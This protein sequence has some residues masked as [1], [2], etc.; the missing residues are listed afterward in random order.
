MANFIMLVGLPCSGKSAYAEKLKKETDG[1]IYRPED[2]IRKTGAKGNAVVI[3][4]INTGIRKNLQAGKTVILD[5]TNT[6]K[7][8]RRK[9]MNNLQE[10]DCEKHCVL[11]AA[12][13]EECLKTNALKKQPLPVAFLRKSYLQF[14]TPFYNEGFD[15]IWLYYPNPRHKGAYGSYKDVYKRNPVPNTRE[16]IGNTNRILRRVAQMDPEEHEYII[17]AYLHEYGKLYHSLNDSLDEHYLNISAYDSLFFETQYNSLL[18]SFLI[19][20][21]LQNPCR[22]LS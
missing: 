13:F 22:E 19:G 7:A 5:Y 8:L 3:N 20:N 1:V 15:R 16:I 14:E 4:M 11:I 17:A 21:Q 9:F 10:M 2:I 12:P 18:I 6:T